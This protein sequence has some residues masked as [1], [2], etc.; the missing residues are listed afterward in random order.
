[1]NRFISSIYDIM[2]YLKASFQ[3]YEHIQYLAYILVVVITDVDILCYE[4]RLHNK[5][6]NVMF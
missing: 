5:I 4:K 2:K 1:M 6:V 3:C